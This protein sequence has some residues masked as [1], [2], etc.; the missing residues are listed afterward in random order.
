M[1]RV[2]PSGTNSSDDVECFFHRLPKTQMHL[3]CMKVE[4]NLKYRKGQTVE[5][6][7][8]F[9]TLPLFR[10]QKMFTGICMFFPAKL[11]PYRKKQGK[12][13]NQWDFITILNMYTERLTYFSSI[14]RQSW[15]VASVLVDGAHLQR[16]CQVTDCSECCFAV[17]TVTV[18][19]PSPKTSSPK[20]LPFKKKIT[21]ENNIWTVGI[22]QIV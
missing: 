16:F 9:P 3:S 22:I 12:A 19:K 5:R 21:V 10:N 17:C 18:T 6:V 1:E 14:S 15:C 4:K 20:S 2:D 8:T 7:G 11:L 13:Q